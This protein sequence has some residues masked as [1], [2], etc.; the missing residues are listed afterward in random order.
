[1]KFL[2]NKIVV[3][4]SIIAFVS[5]GF[6]IFLQ[7]YFSASV[8][9]IK[10]TYA[11]TQL[12]QLQ[13]QIIINENSTDHAVCQFASN[14][15]ILSEA[16]NEEND[17]TSIQHQLNATGLQFLIVTDANIK[18]SKIF[19]NNNHRKTHL[20][21][22]D[23][24]IFH[25][26]LGDGKI[27][28]YFIWDN[29]SLFAISAIKVALSNQEKAGTSPGWLFAGRYIN[30]EYSK[31]LIL[32]EPGTVEIKKEAQ[33]AQSVINKKTSIYTSDLPLYG[34]DNEAVATVEL[35]TQPELMKVLS[36]HQFLLLIGMMVSIFVFTIFIGLYL[37]RYY[38]LPIR[39][40]SLA[41]K[42]KDPEYIKAIN[43]NDPD[44][45]TLQSMIIN[46]FSQ[47]RMLSDMIHQRNDDHMNTFHAAILSKINEAVYATDHKGIITYWNKSAESL[48]LT[49]EEHAV[50]KIAAVLI[51][52]LW[53]KP[54]DEEIH[55]NELKTNGVWQGKL[56]QEIPD[57]S[58][59]MVDLSIS[60]LYDNYG[61]LL[62][63][64]YIVRKSH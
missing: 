11:E 60:C 12:N 24:S 2:R 29:D 41:L 61:A 55:L 51:R 44:I 22:S 6:I 10:R 50:S 49:K 53:A 28:R 8:E 42:N 20:L 21:P 54:N 52:N 39:Y 30:E 31:N 23:T 34:W 13:S 19:C 9:R 5:I 36:G 1:M 63:H 62:G 33:P 58:E 64:L 40:I 4:I 25:K 18:P 57:G 45:K 59:I 17:I 46:I 16:A 26:S 38:I 27:T 37:N 32:Q 35:Q 3:L 43:D 47:E 56:K 15:T 48:Y 14:K 7:L